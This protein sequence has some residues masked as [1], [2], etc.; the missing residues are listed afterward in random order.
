[1]EARAEMM[2]T[3]SVLAQR[4][5]ALAQSDHQF[6]GS[7]V[8]HSMAPTH[9]LAE[10]LLVAIGVIAVISTTA[11]T[12]WRFIRPG[13]TGQGHIKRRILDERPDGP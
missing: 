4:I 6:S 2:L 13:E 7:T 8:V 5:L 3:V 9:T 1:M 12:L 10:V 11:Y